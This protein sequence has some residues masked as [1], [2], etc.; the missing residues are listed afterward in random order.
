MTFTPGPGRIWF[1]PIKKEEV[2]M[3]DKNEVIEAGRLLAAT[4]I[5]DVTL[6]EGAIIFFL[7]WGAEETPEYEGKKYWT[8]RNDPAF[9]MGFLH[10]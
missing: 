7:G 9:I 8:V 4:M 3:S 10:E 1:E 2:I 5:G 6:A